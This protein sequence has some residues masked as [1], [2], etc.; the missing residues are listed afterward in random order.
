MV[1]PQHGN[2]ITLFLFVYI[3]ALARD[4][5]A[6]IFTDFNATGWQP[7]SRGEILVV[8]KMVKL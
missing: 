4:S 2:E 1:L 5:K 6:Y 3:I 7:G 8:R